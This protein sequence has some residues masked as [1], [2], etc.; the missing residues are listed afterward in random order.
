[1][2]SSTLNFLNPISYSPLWGVG[3]TPKILASIHINYWWSWGR[4]LSCFLPFFLLLGEYP[5]TCQ[6]QCQPDERPGLSPPGVGSIHRWWTGLVPFW[7]WTKSQQVRK[8]EINLR[9]ILVYCR[10]LWDAPFVW[11]L[12]W[13]WFLSFVWIIICMRGLFLLLELVFLRLAPSSLFWCGIWLPWWFS[14]KSYFCLETS[15]PD[16]SRGCPF[17]CFLLHNILFS[18]SCCILRLSLCMAS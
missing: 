14:F 6:I 1:M 12:H 8:S 18:M 10:G 5:C 16:D 4:A 13:T 15:W 3:S 9:S 7:W 2:Q 17:C 11:T